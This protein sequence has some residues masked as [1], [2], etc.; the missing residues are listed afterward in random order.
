MRPRDCDN[1]FAI[2]QQFTPQ[3]RVLDLQPYG[4]GNVHDTFRVTVDSPE[5]PYFILQR[6]NIRVFPRPELI[7]ANLRTCS[8]HMERRLA[9]APHNQGRGWEVVRVR[10]TQDGRD[11]CLDS[12]GSF[13]RALS[14]IDRAQSFDILENLEHAGE[15]GYGLGMFHRLLSDL[16]AAD[17]ADTLPGFHV[18]PGYLGHYDKVLAQ[19]GAPETPEA[20]FCR[21]FIS[22]RRAWAQVLEAAKAQGHLQLRPIHGD[23]KVNNVLL[24]ITSGRAVALVDLDTV[25]PGLVLYDI[26]DCLRSGCNPLGEETDRWE[27]VR[28]EPDFC[29]ALLHG[30]FSQARGCLTPGDQEYLYDA[31]RLIAFELGLR[32]FTDYLAGN[33]YFKAR[34]REHNLA[35]ALVQFQLTAS[36]EAQETLIGGIIREKQ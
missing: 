8:A 13:W 32:F 17:L 27:A 29:R 22:Q 19:A 31:I 11:Y 4:N 10:P 15:L 24:D 26:G 9:Q 5:E 12:E 18:T 2:A 30:Y 35:R 14:F 28:F 34:S 7:M 20:V 25:K 33:V 36:I 1:F 16:P 23:P 6:L 21:Q 3:G